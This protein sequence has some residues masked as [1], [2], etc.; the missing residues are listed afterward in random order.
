M[1]S[2]IEK[3]AFDRYPIK[4]IFIQFNITRICE[5]TFAFRKQLKNVDFAMNSKLN[6]EDE[7]FM[8]ISILIFFIPYS[9]TKNGN[10]NFNWCMFFY[11]WPKTKKFLILKKFKI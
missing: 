4:S 10:I 11:L 9:V 3:N 8:E 7:V 5:N 6:V 2:I 1:F